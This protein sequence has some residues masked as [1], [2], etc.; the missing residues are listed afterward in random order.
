ME[1]SSITPK[2]YYGR[3]FERCAL[4]YCRYHSYRILKRNLHM[5]MGEIDILAEDREG[6][7]LIVIEVRGRSKGNFT[8]S[9]MLSPQKILRLQRMAELLALRHR[10]GVRLELLEIVGKLPAPGTVGCLRLK[11]LELFPLWHGLKWRALRIE[12]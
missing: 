11:L 12:R 6:N 5:K 3:L 10:K 4:S 7:S 8:S 9:H 1:T 2:A